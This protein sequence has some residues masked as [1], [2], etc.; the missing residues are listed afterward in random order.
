[1]QGAL[2]SLLSLCLIVAGVMTRPPV[3]LAQTPQTVSLETAMSSAVER[4]PSVVAAARALDAAQARLTQARAGAA[5]QLSVNGRGSYGTISQLGT[6]TG[7]EPTTTHNLSLA[8]SLSLYDGG[9][10]GLQVAQAQAA[11]ESAAAG[12]EAA[13]QDAA[14]SAAQAYFQVLRA[15]R[16]V[17]VREAAVRSAEAEVQQAE[18]FLRAGT[19]ARADVVKVQAALAGAEA[20][21]IAVRGQ[22]EIALAGLRG[23]MAI[24]LTQVIAAVEPAEPVPL[25]LAPGD[26]AAEAATQRPEIK[27]AGADIKGAQ[28]ALRI[29]EIR[30]GLSVSLGAS[31]VV[32]VSPT[33]GPSG[34]SL[35]ATVSYPLLDG[36]RTKA[37]VAE[38]RANL[39]A[40]VARGDVA[41]L[42]IQL[43]AFQAA[44]T[45]RETV[46][47]TA[48]VRT[49]LAAAEESLRVAEGRY[50]AGV[51]TLLEVLD[52]QSSAT[53]ARVTNVQTQYDL[54]LAVVTLRYS[55]GRPLVDRRTASGAAA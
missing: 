30:A 37:A 43:Q 13:R 23:A 51:G 17:E 3:V 2:V 11:V 1:M 19:G 26:A 50:R 9:I 6:P 55:L 34:W 53:Q 40:V 14:L 44:T 38:A 35:S 33:P 5:L 20:D 22:V 28:A 25:V 24:P 4:H 39:A 27:K 42:Q 45:M 36:E 10:T 12:L 46:A 7:G 31:G 21:L 41:A 8:A 54:H 32:Q 48:A 52:A 29:A 16:V 49:A 15:Q 47:R 18:A